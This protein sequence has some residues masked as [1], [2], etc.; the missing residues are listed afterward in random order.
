MIFGGAE[1]VTGLPNTP[2]EK[3][4]MKCMMRAW[5]SFVRD[6]SNGLAKEM[7]WPLYNPK[8]VTLVRLGYNDTSGASFALPA[9][10]DHG[11]PNNESVTK[12]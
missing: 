2:L 3:R 7:R 8:N 4:T 5:A 12:V 1:D 6:P 11:C 10:Y 9:T